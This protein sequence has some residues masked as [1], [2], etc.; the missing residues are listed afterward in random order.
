MLRED[1]K[2]EVSSIA[3]LTTSLSE[4]WTLGQ[5]ETYGEVK[6]PDK[7]EGGLSLT[8]LHKQTLLL[9]PSC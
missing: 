5:V 3:K 9:N 4:T 2:G 1:P 6:T 7:G 8:N